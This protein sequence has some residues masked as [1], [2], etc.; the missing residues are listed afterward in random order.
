MQ[1]VPGHIHV[2][3]CVTQGWCLLFSIALLFV[4]NYAIPFNQNQIQQTTDLSA[5]T[6]GRR[7][8][9]SKA[10]RQ[11]KEPIVKPIIDDI[12]VKG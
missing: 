9:F 10:L 1:A 4:S 5:V 6:R 2:C 11:E 12:Q 8:Y 3:E 7:L